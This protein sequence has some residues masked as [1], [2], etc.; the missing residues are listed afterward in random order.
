MEGV[1]MDRRQLLVRA[2]AGAALAGLAAAPAR[3]ESTPELRGRL[4]DGKGYTL[5]Q[6]RGKVVLVFFWRTGCPVCLDKMGELRANLDGWRD[7]RFQVLGVNTDPLE[8]DW[9]LWE[10]AVLLAV[11]PRLRFP[12]V[13]RRDPAHRDS[14]GA[15]MPAPSSFFIDRTG[16]MVK[17]Y[18]GRMEAGLWD[19]IAELV[20]A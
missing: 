9:R 2:V 16:V 1:M 7:K 19:E 10:Q 12:N 20:L 13:W 11:P 5:A 17:Q 8:S 3:A 18:R 6:E 14:F 4:A 15:D